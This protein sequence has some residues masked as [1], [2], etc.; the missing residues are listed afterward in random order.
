MPPLEVAPC[1]AMA[2]VAPLPCPLSRRAFLKASHFA[3]GPDP[4]LHAGAMQSTSHRD[5]PAHPGVTGAPRCQQPPRGSLLPRD[6]RSRGAELRSETHCA[7]APPPPCTRPE[8]RERTPALQG[9]GLRVHESA[10][11]RTGAST[12]RADFGWPEAPARAREQIHGARLIFDRDSVAPGDPAKLRIPPTTHQDFYALRAPCPQPR[13]PCCHLGGLN[14]LRWDHRRQDNGTSY[15]RHFQALPSPPALMCKRA[16]SSVELGDFKIG[17]GPMCSEQKQAYRP[18]G[19]PPD[20]YDKAQATAHI[21]HVNICPGDGLFRDRTTKAEHF[22]AREPEH[23]VLHHDQTPASHILEGNWCPGP[24]SL[25]TSMH[26]F[27]G[28]LP[29]TKPPSRHVPHDKLKSHVCLGDS[30]LLG[31]FLQ[32]SMGSDYCPP[33]KAQKSQKAPS[34]HLLQS[35]LPQG[36]YS[37]RVAGG[38]GGGSRRS[39]SPAPAGFAPPTAR[40]WLRLLKSEI[41]RGGPRSQLCPRTTRPFEDLTPPYPPTSTE[42]SPPAQSRL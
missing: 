26:S 33:E 17:Y 11:V 9:S 27:H 20:R 5:F 30:S 37:A 15:Q 16:S 6:A 10:R 2:A 8:T 22:Y 1:P 24:G 31:Q 28:Q 39:S 41:P 7:F 14:P 18:Q 42:A 23:F 32:T 40:P 38:G 19:L 3:L 25:T 34:L 12:M 35:S 29:V 21:Y 4:R 13:A 36:T